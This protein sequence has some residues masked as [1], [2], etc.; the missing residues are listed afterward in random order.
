MARSEAERRFDE[1][2][3]EMD[4]GPRLVIVNRYGRSEH[5]YAYGN[6]FD[7]SVTTILRA[8]WPKPAL[9]YWGINSV[10]KW[11]A[12]NAGQVYA[13]A[14]TSED[15]AYEFM[16]QVPWSQRDK[17]GDVGTEIHSLVEA[18]PDLAIDSLADNVRPYMAGFDRWMQDADASILDGEFPVWGECA[19]GGYGG[20]VDLLVS[21]PKLGVGLLDVKTAEKGPFEDDHTQVAAYA[22][23][24][25]G[26]PQPVEWAGLLHCRPEGT[27]LHMVD[28]GPSFDAFC[29]AYA[30]A[31][32]RGKLEKPEGS[33]G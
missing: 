19:A 13:M 9:L 32:F 16:R 10:S 6:H 15:A 5:W 26:L 4:A 17:A 3:A 8:G 21:V 33:N 7:P 1:V 24:T 14:K 25:A 12:E 28:I 2:K 31:K 20:K 18:Y 11:A 27:T 22:R 30:I 29:A 23:A